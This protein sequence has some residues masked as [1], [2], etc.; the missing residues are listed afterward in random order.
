MA[1]ITDLDDINQGVEITLNT[2]TRQFTLN[3]AGNL[4]DDGVTLQAIY[5]FFKVAW[6]SDPTLIPFPFPMVSITPEQFEFIND[7]EPSN[8]ASRKLIR[9]GGWR[10][11]SRNG[12]RKREYLGVVTLGNIDAVDKNTGDKAY[13][14]FSSLTTTTEFTYAG[15]VN[16]AIQTFGDADNG[17]IDFTTDSTSIFIRIEGKTYDKSTSTAIGLTG[18]LPYNVQRFPLAESI[19]LEITD[20][21]VTIAAALGAGQKYDITG[22]GTTGR[23]QYYAAAQVSDTDIYTPATDLDGGPFNFGIVISGSDNTGTGNVLGKNDLYTL[24]QYLLRQSSDI[25]FEGTG[26]VKP[27]NIQDSL[28]S[29]VGPTLESLNAVNLDGGGTGV[30]VENFA[31]GDTNSIKLRDNLT[32]LRSFPFVSAGFLNFNDNLVSDTGPAEYFMFFEYTTRTSGITD[33]VM[34]APSGQEVT[35]TSAGSN[36]PV[37]S[38]SDYINI[39][40]AVDDN[41]N[42]IWQVTATVSATSGTFSATRVDDVT[43]SQESFTGVIEENPLNSP[44]SILVEDTTNSPIEGVINSAQIAFNFSYSSNVQGGRTS[45]TD[46]DVIIRALGLDLGSY[47]QTSETISQSAAL[48]F[49][50]VAGLERNY[51]NP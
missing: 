14:N 42:G 19:D 15:P 28:L 39:T 47:V 16:E 21:D 41:N 40:G 25:D 44:D 17:N 38:T 29:F 36:F 13:Y 34:G 49:S 27:G 7:W 5:S 1:L 6:K 20:S 32:T 48:S 23:I 11:L 51:S 50:V 37:L 43:I 18:T 30:A 24:V 33:L 3:E 9:T 2:G 35:F 4:S 22:S 8:D 10:E 12:N 31:S 46:A 45:N 26:S